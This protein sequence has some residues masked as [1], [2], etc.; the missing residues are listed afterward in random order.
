VSLASDAIASTARRFMREF[1]IPGLALAVVAPGVPPL[2]Q[3]HGVRTIGEPAEVDGD[4]V[5]AIASNTK[6]FLGACLALLVDEGRLAWDDPVVRH[7]PEFRMA[8][9]AVTSMMTVR[10]LLVHRSGLPLGAGDLMQFPRTDHTIAEVL[11]ALRHFRSNGF[12]NGYAY[13]N[14]LYLVAGV[15]LERVSGL[16]WPDFV[17]TR[18]FAPLGMDGAVGLPAR[19]RTANRAARHMRL[20]PP[21]IGLGRLEVVPADES[22]LIGPAGGINASAR[23]L[24]PWLQVQL[25]R[26]ALPDGGRLWSAARAAEMWTPHTIVSSG[27]GPTPEQPQ[28]SVMQGYALGWGVSDYRGRRMLTHGGAL[29]GAASR[30]TLLPEEGIGFTLL[31]N[32]GDSEPVSGLRYALLDQLL[33]VA[34]PDWLVATRAN[35][36]AGERQVLD[37]LADHDFAA[38]AGALSL[39]LDGYV[40]RYRDAWYGDLLVTRKGS[41]L[42]VNF[43]RTQAFKGA[44][45]PFGADAF[46]TRFARGA[47]EDAVLRFA[48]VEGAFT[49]ITLRA[50]S[51]IADLSFDFHDLSFKPVRDAAHGPSDPHP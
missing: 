18:V 31:S 29:A 46:R 16:A 40:G 22:P 43:T 41:G 28:R 20:G 49:G 23:G 8:D 38:P 17:E 2:V 14:S 3:G 12:R 35:V 7:V 44:L 6:A 34:G 24:V 37:A 42:A 19:V 33:G 26:G 51:P 11:A 25:A 45:E 30:T 50:L 47:G 48:V 9:A 36:A 21:V 27:A 1:E 4:T 13:D 5:F 39:A 10:D 15:L 32:S